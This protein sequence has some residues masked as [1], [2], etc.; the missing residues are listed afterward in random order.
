MST[1]GPADTR[2]VDLVIGGMTCAACA[3]R[4]ERKLNKLDGVTATVNYA[5]EKATVHLPLGMP[6][7]DVVTRVEQTGYTAHP[8]VPAK[9]DDGSASDADRVRMLWRR[10]VVALLLGAPAGDLSLTL[11]LVPSL[12]FPGWQWL[13]LAMTLPV[14]AWCAWPFHRKAAIG[15]RHGSSSMDTLVSLGILAASGWSLYTIFANGADVIQTNNGVWGLIFQPGGSVYL[16]VA[17]GVTIFVLAG[18]LFEAKAKHRAG[19]ALRALAALGAKDVRVLDDDGSVRRIPAAE[20]RVGQ[21]FVVRPGETIATDGEVLSGSCAV[22]TATMTGE[23]VP[24]EVGEGD[25]VVGGTIALG[26]RLIVR[27]TRV[28]ADT[29]LAQ[30]VQLVE[31]AQADK[32][33]VQR[34][35]DRISGVFVPV[36]VGLA[37]LTTL[38]WWWFDGSTTRTVSAGLAVLIIACPCALGLATPTALMV[39]SGRG[40]QLGVFLKGYQALETAREIDTVVLDK[41][42]TLTVGRMT[43]VDLLPAE[44]VEQAEVLRLA[45]AVE[46]ASEHAVAAAIADR[47]RRE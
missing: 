1:T 18:R 24:V 29:Q 28:G 46:D 13:L 36:V 37:V 16:E 20:L 10:L 7:A 15:L 23:S 11:A 43:M 42:G 2:S 45:G 22:D 38:G 19:D 30:L 33:G 40:A 21:R 17:S 32:A 35:A 41:T 8:V 26:G 5:T 6:V 27:A 31:R 25:S 14:V 39:A 12:R 9:P 44:G 47:A 4:V 34:L 3:A